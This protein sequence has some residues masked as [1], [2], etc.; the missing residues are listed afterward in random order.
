MV[1]NTKE[2]QIVKI[3]GQVAEKGQ[4]IQGLIRV[5]GILQPRP[6]ICSSGK[7]GERFYYLR[8]FV[9]NTEEI[10]IVETM[11]SKDRQKVGAE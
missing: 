6:Y 11:E 9:W 8:L 2:I 3:L 10:Q 5:F 1:W 4:K 7:Y